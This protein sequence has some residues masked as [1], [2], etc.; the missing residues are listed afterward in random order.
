MKCKI[1]TFIVLTLLVLLSACS[2]NKKVEMQTE[3]VPVR[4]PLVL[5]HQAA[6]SGTDLYNKELY[7]DAIK[8]FSEAIDLFTEASATASAVDSIAENIEKMKLNIAKS[9][10]ELASE[11]TEMNMYEDALVF[12][13]KALNIYTSIAP[14]LISEEEL[15]QNIIG[16]YNN[17]AIVAKQAGK[18]ENALEYYNQILKL[19][20][21]DTDTIYAKFYVLKDNLNDENRAYNVLI[22]YAE[23]TRDAKAFINIGDFYADK[24]NMIEASKY[25]QKALAI[26]PNVDVYR[27][28]ANYYRITKDWANANVYLLKVVESNPEPSELAQIYIMIGKNYDEMKDKKKMVEYYEKS[29][30]IERDPQLALLLASYYNSQKNYAKVISNSNITLSIDPKNVDALMLRG[31]AYFQT[32]NYTA[33]KAD[34]ERLKNHP[35]YGAQAT[36]LLKNIPK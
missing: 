36:N 26:E 12:Y 13:N 16:L 15:N 2:G 27:R 4:N 25:Y 33:A 23:L 21:K 19:N 30:S 11:S 24:G 10:I 20:P 34:L 29:L 22:E 18:Y 28:L 1:M 32:K 3:Q 14:T 35:K 17:M 9:Y 8:S 7:N 6:T 5:A 31:V